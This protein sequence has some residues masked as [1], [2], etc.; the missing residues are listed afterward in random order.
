MVG[1]MFLYGCDHHNCW[2]ATAV[3]TKCG[4]CC[5][6]QAGDRLQTGDR[7]RPYKGGTADI[8]RDFVASCRKFGVS[9]CLYFIPA[10]DGALEQQ[11]RTADQYLATQLAM[12]R[13][14]LTRYGHCERPV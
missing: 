6:R 5:R 2:L 12:L 9:P 1:G 14:L 11:N 13:E 4:S 10:E 3:L 8:V 7:L